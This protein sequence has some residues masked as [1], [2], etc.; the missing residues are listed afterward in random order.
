MSKIE[1]APEAPAVEAKPAEPP[2]LVRHKGAGQLVV[3]LGESHVLIPP[4]VEVK[5]DAEVW[6]K[7]KSLRDGRFATDFGISAVRAA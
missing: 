7:I 1:K 5:M 3:Q 4:H 2:V 6:L